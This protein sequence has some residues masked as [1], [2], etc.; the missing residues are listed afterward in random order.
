MIQKLTIVSCLFLSLFAFRET[1]PD[2]HKFMPV[3]LQ[4]LPADTPPY[5]REI[6]EQA[7]RPDAECFYYCEIQI[8]TLDALLKAVEIRIS[9]ETTQAQAIANQKIY[10]ALV[11]AAAPIFADG[12]L[13]RPTDATSNSISIFRKVSAPFGDK[14]VTMR[15]TIRILKGMARIRSYNQ[16]LQSKATVEYYRNLRRWRSYL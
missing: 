7:D 6:L 13:W 3:S 8:S 1:L 9:A 5:I 15:R 10:A 12:L 11:K 4:H 2:Q 14:Q 16:L